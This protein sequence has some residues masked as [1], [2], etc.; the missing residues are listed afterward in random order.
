MDF[1]WGLLECGDYL[2][3][4]VSASRKCRQAAGT[5]QEKVLNAEL[6]ERRKY[7]CWE[8]LRALGDVELQKL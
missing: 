7:M 4:P 5:E 2:A 6:G 8:T 3:F 1:I